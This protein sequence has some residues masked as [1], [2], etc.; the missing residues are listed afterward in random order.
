M[1]PW[2]LIGFTLG[3]MWVALVSVLVAAWFYE[4]GKRDVQPRAYDGLPE[5]LARPLQVL[6]AKISDRHQALTDAIE[7]IL[8]EAD[9]YDTDQTRAERIVAEYLERTGNQRTEAVPWIQEQTSGR[10]RA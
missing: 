4:R 10:R 7:Q 1:W 5:D 2:L 3:A 6:E 9:Y 8:Y